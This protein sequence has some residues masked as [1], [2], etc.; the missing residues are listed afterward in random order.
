MWT[1]NFGTL[2]DVIVDRSLRAVGVAARLPVA[3]EDVLGV[4][5][6]RGELCE[7]GRRDERDE[8]KYR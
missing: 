3:F 8:N 4:L 7:S 1:S 6:V 2:D 5:R